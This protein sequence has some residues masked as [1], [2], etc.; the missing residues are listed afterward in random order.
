MKTIFLF[1]LL[2]VTLNC[3]SQNKKDNTERLLFG[4][5]H[6]E[7]ELRESL[8][9]SLIHNVIGKDKILIKE[10]ADAVK[11]AEV[12]LF[13]IYSEENIIRQHPYEVHFIDNYWIISGTFPLEPRMVGGT[14]LIIIDARDSRILRITHGK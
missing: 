6:A 14:F 5:E 13:S 9:D 2:L 7:K 10:E 3:C 11:I 8:S 4:R 12:V 1:M